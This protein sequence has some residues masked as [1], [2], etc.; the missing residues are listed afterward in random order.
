[1]KYYN[2]NMNIRHKYNVRSR[3]TDRRECFLLVWWFQIG[4]T[5]TRWR[6]WCTRLTV[7]DTSSS[8]WPFPHCLTLQ[9]NIHQCSLSHVTYSTADNVVKF[10]STHLRQHSWLH[11]Y[12]QTHYDQDIIHKT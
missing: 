8:P 12:L 7:G 1:M 3:R 6:C 9:S 2:A 4:V 5:V 11:W 10:H